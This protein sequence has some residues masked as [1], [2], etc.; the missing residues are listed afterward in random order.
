MYDSKKVRLN[1]MFNTSGKCLNVA[2]DHGVFNE[3]SFLNGLENIPRVVN[4]LVEAGPDAIQMN[5]G[6][7]DV[8]QNFPGKHKPALVMRDTTER[9]E[10]VEAGTARL[11]GSNHDKI[12]AETFRLLDDDETYAA[13]ARSHNPF[14]DGHASERIVKVLLD[15]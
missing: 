10:G 14:G 12:V 3:G 11:V 2:I 9:P 15:A 6:Q 7:C 13:M 8:L 1:R 5:I 4:Q